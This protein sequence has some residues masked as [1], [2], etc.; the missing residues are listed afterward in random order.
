MESRSEKKER[1]K[2]HAYAVWSAPFGRCLAPGGSCTNRPVKAHSVQRQG[3]IRLISFDGHVV[4]LRQR[5]DLMK[6]GP[7]ISF[8]SVGVKKA[9]TFTGLCQEHDAALFERIDMN[10][11]RLDDVQSLSLHAYRAILR[12]THVCLEAAA[13]L[14]SVYQKQCDFELVDRNVPTR[15]GLFAVERMAVAYETWHYKEYID[16]AFLRGDF[17]VLSHDVIDLGQTGPCIA[18]S[19][20]FSL[21]EIQVAEDTPRIAL[22]VIP[23]SGGATYAVLSYIDR[24]L[25]AAR[26]WLKPVLAATGSHQRYLLSRLILERSDNFVINPALYAQWSEERREVVRRFFLATVLENDASFEDARLN[27]FDQNAASEGE[28]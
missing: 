26:A 25:N 27:L 23:V 22:N 15:G 2:G 7:T 6:R 3:P 28:A 18:V 9:T 14:Q 17:A 24:D 11:G 20:L 12:E 10:P 8:E 21:D 19:S 16:R 5:L 4:M 1:L 13:K